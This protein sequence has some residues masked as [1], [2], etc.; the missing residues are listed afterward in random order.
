MVQLLLDP[1]LSDQGFF[2]LRAGERSLF[3]FLDSDWDSARHVLG[4]LHLAIRAF[5]KVGFFGLNKL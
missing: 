3:D 2:N 5:T 4:Q 1:N